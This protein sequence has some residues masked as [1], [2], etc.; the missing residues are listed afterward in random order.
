MRG[1]AVACR[2]RAASRFGLTGLYVQRVASSQVGMIISRVAPCQ[3][4]VIEHLQVGSHPALEQPRALIGIG[5]G[6]AGELAVSFDI[7]HVMTKQ[8]GLVGHGLGNVALAG[9]GL[10]HDQGVGT[11]T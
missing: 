11:L 4:Q 8:G 5:Q 1:G 9:A 3:E 10:A 6:I 7:G 2:A